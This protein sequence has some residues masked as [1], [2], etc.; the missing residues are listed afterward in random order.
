MTELKPCPFCG[1]TNLVGSLDVGNCMDHEDCGAPV[2][3]V[4]TLHCDECGCQIQAKVPLE[5]ARSADANAKV[6]EKWNRRAERTCGEWRGDPRPD[7][8]GHA[9]EHEDDELWCEHCD[10]ELDEEWAYCPNCG[11]KVVGQ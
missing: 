7:A 6:F 1:S 2:G 8:I 11:A 3:V 10:I 5:D 4:A 9:A